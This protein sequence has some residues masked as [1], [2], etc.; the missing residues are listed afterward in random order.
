MR[1]Q[2]NDIHSIVYARTNRIA[3]ER[4]QKN[5]SWWGDKNNAN[6]DG[7][8]ALSLEWLRWRLIGPKLCVCSL[9]RCVCVCARGHL[10]IH[11]THGSMHRQQLQ[12]QFNGSAE[13]NLQMNELS[14]CSEFSIIRSR[15][16]SSAFHVASVAKRCK[17]KWAERDEA[18][19]ARVYRIHDQI[20]RVRWLI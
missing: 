11:R 15:A 2:A 16:N 1:T 12:I 10:L 8:K 17:E 5:G 18:R 14:T 13:I 6:I 19:K 9:D 20:A 4:R 3:T 7:N